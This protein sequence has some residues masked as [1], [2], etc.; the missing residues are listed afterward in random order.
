LGTRRISYQM[1]S[2]FMGFGGAAGRIAEH[3]MLHSL[4][5]G[6]GCMTAPQRQEG[7]EN[8]GNRGNLAR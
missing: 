8:A 4:L 5:H 6:N 3:S 2:L 1:P 7:D